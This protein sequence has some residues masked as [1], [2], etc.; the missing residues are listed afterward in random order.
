MLLMVLIHQ[1]IIRSTGQAT[2]ETRHERK[3]QFN[4][5]LKKECLQIKERGFEICIVG[6]VNISRANI[7][8]FPRLR[9]EEQHVLA[10]KQFNEEFLPET[11][12]VD[13]WRERHGENA[14][15]YTWYMRGVKEGTDCAR[16]DMIL[17]TRGLYNCAKEI[18]IEKWG[19]SQCGSDHTFMWIEIDGFNNKDIESCEKEY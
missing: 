14:K 3:R 7:D 5:L 4:T 6:D 2:G 12:L 15:G 9:T 10:R 19:G 16:V 18:E 13:A 17:V 8:T 11:E 1:Y